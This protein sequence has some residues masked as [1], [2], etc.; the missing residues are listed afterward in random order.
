MLRAVAALLFLCVAIGFS[1]LGLIVARDHARIS[2]LSASVNE[3]LDRLESPRPPEVAEPP[4]PVRKQTPKPPDRPLP[5]SD[6]VRQAESDLLA[7]CRQRDR[8]RDPVKV[9]REYDLL[10]PEQRELVDEAGERLKAGGFDALNIT[11]EQARFLADHDDLIGEELLTRRRLELADKLGATQITDD[12]GTADAK[13]IVTFKLVFS[14]TDSH[15]RT[16]LSVATAEY[17]KAG[18]DMAAVPESYKGILR[19]HHDILPFPD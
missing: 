7:R 3:R 15:T 12:L 1:L 17:R 14:L 2:D 9:R 16:L 13:K 10:A 11:T 8:A 18:R 4:P 19:D 5:L 6:R